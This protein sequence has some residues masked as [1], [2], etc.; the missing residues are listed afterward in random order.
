M[1]D[2]TQDLLPLIEKLEAQR[3]KLSTT[4]AVL[5]EQA[6]LEAESDA[7]SGSGAAPRPV[8]RDTSVPGRIRPDEFFRMSIP[9][10]IKKYLTIMKAPQSSRAIADGLKSGGMLTN[11]KNWS[12]IVWTAIARMV[13]ADAL[14]N[15]P[16]G[17]GL[18]EW[19]P[20]RPA[21]TKPA[22][23]KKG[24]KKVKT[25]GAAKTTAAPPLDYRGFVAKE[26]KTGK[27]MKDAAA[28]WKKL[29]EAALGN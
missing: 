6:G 9:D 2:D 16:N 11:A 17:Y 1:A 27:S 4:I 14:A 13:D 22:K 10:A 29:K 7:P 20:N 18:T 5:R 24:K 12:A 21:P 3:D 15:T 25:N 26:M 23:K 8:N 28:A 19:Y